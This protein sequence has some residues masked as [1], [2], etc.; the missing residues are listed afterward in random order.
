VDGMSWTVRQYD[1][2]ER[3]ATSTALD[4][5]V[6]DDIAMQTDQAVAT[7]RLQHRGCYWVVCSLYRDHVGWSVEMQA[8]ALGICRRTFY[9]R[10]DRSHVL[11]LAT[12]IDLN[13]GLGTPALR[14]LRA[15]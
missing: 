3:T 10:V 5:A 7:L 1:Y 14:Q 8:T 4:Y 13:A 6:I 9:R 15:V 11:I 2:E 12:L